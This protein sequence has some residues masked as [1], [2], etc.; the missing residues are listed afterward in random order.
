MFAQ[1]IIR[2]WRDASLYG[3]AFALHFVLNRYGYI[4]FWIF[5]FRDDLEG[6]RWCGPIVAPQTHG[7]K[8]NQTALLEIKEHTLRNVDDNPVAD[9]VRYDMA[10][11]DTQLFVLFSKV[12]PGKGYCL[13]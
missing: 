8:T 7:K 1:R 13:R 6:A 10:V 11:V 9:D 4:P 3:F 2:P 5:F 12:T